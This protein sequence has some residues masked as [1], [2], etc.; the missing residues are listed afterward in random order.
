MLLITILLVFSLV[1]CNQEAINEEI[2]TDI[3]DSTEFTE[4]ELG[5]VINV[6]EYY[7]E[8]SVS[9][10]EGTL[11]TRMYYG[12]PGYG[13][14]PDTDIQEYPFIL[15]LDDPIDV[16]V[17]EG[18]LHNSDKFEVTEIQVVPI[19]TENIE[20]VEQY[21]NKRIKIQGTLFEAL[22][23]HHHTNVLIEVEKVLD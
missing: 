13:E 9:T 6:V 3:V 22:T 12:P 14:N 1:A 16:L 20:I 17:Q 19:N 5:E 2:T 15:Q 18:D 21:I 7:F 10:I 11:I 4:D 8:P 23:G